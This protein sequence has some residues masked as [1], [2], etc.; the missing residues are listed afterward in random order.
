MRDEFC[1]C[2]PSNDVDKE[3]ICNKIHIC[4]FSGLH[5]LYGCVS[6]NV[7]LEKM[8]YKQWRP[9]KVETTGATLNYETLI[10]RL[11]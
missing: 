7:L 5:E 8:I 9:T 11:F 10:S 4:D 2:V 1:E 6:S 3:M